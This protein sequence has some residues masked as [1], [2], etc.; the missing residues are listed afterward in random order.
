MR[1]TQADL[2]FILK[3][4]DHHASLSRRTSCVVSYVNS[5]WKKRI[6]TAIR[7]SEEPRFWAL[8]ALHLA[9]E[10][11]YLSN[12]RNTIS[13]IP[14]LINIQRLSHRHVD[15]VH[16]LRRGAHNQPVLRDIGGTALSL[17]GV[18]VLRGYWEGAR[19]CV[20]DICAFGG[21]FHCHVFADLWCW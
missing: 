2:T 17:H 15:Q 20:L 18:V 19:D 5:L 4:L 13:N 11:T 10:K 7:N 1:E 9:V 21:R 12:H 8:L 16:P 14:V 3:R 6:N